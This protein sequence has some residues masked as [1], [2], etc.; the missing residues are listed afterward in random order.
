MRPDAFR[1]RAGNADRHAGDHQVGILYSARIVVR[2]AVGELDLDRPRAHLGGRIGRHQ[3]A[4]KAELLDAARQRRADQSK[5][6][7]RDALE[8]RLRGHFGSGVL[9]VMNL[10]IVS[11]KKRLASSVPIVMRSALGRP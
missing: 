5:P 3:L 8:G 10:V 2:D 7:Q 1:Q 9:A 11:M 4:R 6:Y